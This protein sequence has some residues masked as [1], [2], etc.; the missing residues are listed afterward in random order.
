MANIV[1]I[2]LYRDETKLACFLTAY[3][4]LAVDEEMIIYAIEQKEF[5]WL[6]YVWAFG[7]NY[8]GP[9]QNV[10]ASRVDL[11]NLFA[12][13]SSKHERTIDKYKDMKIVCE[14]QMLGDDD[15]L[16]ALL[17]NY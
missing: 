17:K 13:I 5:E 8:I 16:Y 15:I 10:K 4:E 6:S 14:W 2:L 3:Y 1:K 7:K 11:V 12:M 9:R